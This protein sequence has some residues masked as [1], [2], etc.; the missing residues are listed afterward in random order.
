[1]AQRLPVDVCVI[2]GGPAGSTFAGRLAA[3]GHAVAVLE[4]RAFPRPH[5]GASLPPSMFPLLEQLGVLDAVERAGFVRAVPPIVKWPDLRDRPPIKASPAGL[6]ID[7]GR[8]DH[9]LLN[10]ARIRGA[11]VFEA[12]RAGGPRKCPQT[13]RWLIPVHGTNAGFEV[14]A[15]I[16]VDASG[17]QTKGHCHRFSVPTVAV[18]GYWGRSNGADP[19]GRLD[20]GEAEW[21]W[22]A[23]VGKSQAIAAVFLDPKRLSGLDRRGIAHLYRMLLTQSNLIGPCLKHGG[24]LVQVCDATSRACPPHA[25]R[26]FIRV[27]DASLK[28][29]PLSSQGIQTAIAAAIQAAIVCNTLLVRPSAADAAISFYEA[30]Q[31]ERLEQHRVKAGQLYADVAVRNDNPFWIS[32][33]CSRKPEESSAARQEPL[34]A[35]TRIA[36]AP[37]VTFETVPV[38]DQDIIVNRPAVRTSAMTRPVAY[39]QG[40]DLVSVLKTINLNGSAYA[41]VQD[42]S[43]RYPEDFSW[44][45]MRWLWD[46]Q[47]IVSH[48]HDRNQSPPGGSIHVGPA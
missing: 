47:I 17:R 33:A 31:S 22:Y 45:V 5:I 48:G 12:A 3:M 20:T 34:T 7:R 15:R 4:A 26:D 18:Y 46:K 28:L 23:P 10:H 14:T 37:D 39:L 19:A 21:M 35:T 42:L 32:R 30:R 41:A 29:D 13:G 40:I 6:H 38:I 11:R 9:I 27:G 24:E 44:S 25:T 16:V 2:G 1:M 36:L 43:Q 8:F